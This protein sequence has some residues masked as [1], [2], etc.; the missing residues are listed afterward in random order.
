[1]LDEL[2]EIAT[3]GTFR[4]GQGVCIYISNINFEA[5]YS[6]IASPAYH[7]SLVRVFAI[8][9]FATRDEQVFNS[10]KEWIHSLKR[11]ST[12]ISQSGEIQRMMFFNEQK[13]IVDAL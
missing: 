1:M 7:I 13:K 8:N 3:R 5:T 2:E 11:H 10:V 6:Y 9:S 4:T 12:L